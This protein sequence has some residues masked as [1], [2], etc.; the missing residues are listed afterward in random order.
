MPLKFSAKFNESVTK[1]IAKKFTNV[2]ENLLSRSDARTLGEGIVKEMRAL[3][4]KGISPIKSFGRFPAYKS[5]KEGYPASVK[6]SYPS[7]RTTPVNLKL[8]GRMLADLGYSVT[9]KGIEIG[10]SSRDAIEKERGHR[11]GANG[12]PER[13]TIPIAKFGEEFAQ[14][15]QDIY[16]KV[17]QR[18]AKKL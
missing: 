15:I 16:L 11:E 17:V 10:Y 12:Q 14:K 9:K 8:T 6:K 13:P 1:A 3:I 2:E 4:S 18:N 5:P 7:K